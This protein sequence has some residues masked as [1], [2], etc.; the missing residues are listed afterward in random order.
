MCIYIAFIQHSTYT[1]TDTY[2]HLLY[3][4]TDTYPHT[5]H[6]HTHICHIN[7]HIHTH[8]CHINTR[9][10]THTCPTSTTV[11]YV[12][13]CGICGCVHKNMYIHMCI[14]VAHVDVYKSHMCIYV[15]YVGV[16]KSQCV[17]MWHIWV[18]L[19]PKGRD[20]GHVRAP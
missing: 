5:T 11:T 19:Q 17:F 4:Y 14:D 1:Y 2:L 3:K 13:L 8:I 18:H 12:F 20:G 16:Y 10:H 15:A 9:M 6:I 7:T